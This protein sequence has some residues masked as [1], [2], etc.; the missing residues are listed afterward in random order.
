MRNRGKL[1]LLVFSAILILVLISIGRPGYPSKGLG[2]V[3]EGY[4][5]LEKIFAAPFGFVSGIF[6]N[7]IILVDTRLENRELKQKNNELQV[8][9]MNLLELRSENARLRSMLEFKKQYQDFALHSA[10]LLTQDITQVFKTAIID[11]GRNEGFFVNM[12]IV[13]PNGVVGRVV[14]VTPHTSQV[15]LI[16]DPNSAIPALVQS[17]RVKGIVKGRGEASLTLE[18]VRSK[19]AVHIG[20]YVVTSGL[21]G[22][23]PKGL[24]LGIVKDVVRDDAKLFAE[25]TLSPCIDVNKIEEI[26][27]IRKNV[28]NPD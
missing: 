7:Y 25:I 10:S 6:E 2:F 24:K 28:A 16:T 26:F 11:R 22:I 9:C 17:S 13:S 18:Y 20:D 4:Y 19:E 15:L 12:P 23:F 27:G 1:S 21:L 8:Q 3:R 14:A 5:F